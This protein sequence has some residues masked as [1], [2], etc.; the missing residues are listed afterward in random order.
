MDR[1]G[2]GERGQRGLGEGKGRRSEMKKDNRK[3]R[4]GGRK[5]NKPVVKTP[6][7]EEVF[8]LINPTTCC[9]L[10][11]QSLIFD[12]TSISNSIGVSSSSRVVLGS[13]FMFSNKNRSG[14][15]TRGG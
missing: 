7:S 10:V 14:I 3:E 12:S 9:F 5:E 1:K 4:A 8:H 6:C 13:V 2:K 11:G 15:M